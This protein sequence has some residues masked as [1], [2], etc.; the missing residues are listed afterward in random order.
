MADRG[1]I[2]IKKMELAWEWTTGI[3]TSG[4][5]SSRTLIA[6]TPG[7]LEVFEQAYKKLDEVVGDPYLQ[8]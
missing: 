8:S 1:D 6:E 5:I 2:I 3:K 7:V 4:S